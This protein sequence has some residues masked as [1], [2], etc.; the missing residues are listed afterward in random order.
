MFTGKTSTASNSSKQFPKEPFPVYPGFPNLL[1]S[2]QSSSQAAGDNSPAAP[3]A[4]AL[5]DVVKYQEQ[6]INS[7]K[8]Q[9][10]EHNSFIKDCDTLKS[11]VTQLLKSEGS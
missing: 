7:Y 11:W 9:V 1:T 2:S 6:L 8:S 10:G 4:S 5:S 3:S